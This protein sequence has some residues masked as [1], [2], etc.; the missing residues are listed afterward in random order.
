MSKTLVKRFSLGNISELTIP[1]T[2]QAYPLGMR[3][4]IEDDT[5]RA[6]KEFIYV[7]AHDALTAYVPLILTYGS[8]AAAEVVTA[9]TAK[10]SV[11]TRIVV[12]QVAF[13]SSSYYGFVQVKGDAT[14]TISS[15]N[16]V[17]GQ[18]CKAYDATC[19]DETAATIT[20][21]SFGMF[22]A[23]RTGAGDVAVYLFDRLVT[24][25]GA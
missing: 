14:I 17:A 21:Y 22:T 10:S 12:P 5:K 2:T 1:A 13:T 16:A 11:Y 20:V 24:I 15:G 4:Q 8:T 18:V 7:K 6:I 23:A 25:D 19:V 3:I 9:A